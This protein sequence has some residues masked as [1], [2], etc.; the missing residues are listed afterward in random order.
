MGTYFTPVTIDAAHKRGPRDQSPRLRVRRQ[1]RRPHLDGSP[2]AHLDL[3]HIP[4]GQPASRAAVQGRP[5]CGV[6]RNLGCA[7][8]ASA[9]LAAGIGLRAHSPFNRSAGR[10]V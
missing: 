10:P 5:A 1:T 3:S 6:F 4:V 2:T 9:R 8:R 7:L